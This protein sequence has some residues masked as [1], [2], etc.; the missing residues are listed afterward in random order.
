MKYIFI[1]ITAVLFVGCDYYDNRLVIHNKT[2][3]T[4]VVETS[5][6]TIPIMP[7]ENKVEYYYRESI[8]PKNKRTFAFPGKVKEW[9]QYISKSKNKKLN[10]FFYNVDTLKKYED[11]DF[12]N[13]NRLYI[14]KKAFTESKLNKLKWIIEYE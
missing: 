8:L 14:K 6:D 12:I 7:C 1:L 11:M 5:L 3:L 2:N 9:S 4:I 10:V 13:R